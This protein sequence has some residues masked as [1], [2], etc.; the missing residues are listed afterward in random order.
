MRQLP[1]GRAIRGSSLR[2]FSDSALNIVPQNRS[3]AFGRSQSH[4]SD[5]FNPQR[6]F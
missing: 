4:P 3:A 1:S 6:E 5:S 2:E